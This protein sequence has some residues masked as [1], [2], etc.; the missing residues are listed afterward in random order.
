VPLLDEK[1]VLVVN[2]DLSRVA[3][4]PLHERAGDVEVLGEDPI[5]AI[6]PA[7]PARG[8][9]VLRVDAVALNV[10][11]LLEHLASPLVVGVADGRVRRRLRGVLPSGLVEE[12][13]GDGTFRRIPLHVLPV[14]VGVEVHNRLVADAELDALDLFAGVAPP[15]VMVKDAVDG[16]GFSVEIE[17]AHVR[18][19]R[20]P[21][22]GRLDDRLASR[23]GRGCAVCAE[24]RLADR[25]TDGASEP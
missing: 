22:V 9:G 1:A 18:P 21:V 12:R 3:P 5:V 16:D 8:G 11:K 24:D 2:R 17:I 10:Q 19:S 6:I 20:S 13:L 14:N 7:G 23:L 15:A 4:L 25:P